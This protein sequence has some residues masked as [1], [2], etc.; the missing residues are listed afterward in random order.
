MTDNDSKN[1][2]YSITKYLSMREHSCHELLKKLTAKGYEKSLCE[3][4]IA[5]FSKADIQSDLRY[6]EMIVRS[7]VAKGKGEQLIRNELSQHAIA[8][9]LIELAITEQDVD[10]DALASDVAHKKFGSKPA[11]D[12]Q[13]QQKRNRFLLYR[14]FSHEQIRALKS[15]R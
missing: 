8:P 5:Q 6:A 3:Q 10:W 11:K 1:I 12:W 13:E 9:E 2:K 7:R 15:V 14:G 4:R